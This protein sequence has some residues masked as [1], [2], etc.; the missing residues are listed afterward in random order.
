MA[1][2][3]RC[4]IHSCQMNTFTFLSPCVRA[5]LGTPF[6]YDY[7]MNL[8]ICILQGVSSYLSKISLLTD[9][10]CMYAHL[11][12]SS[13]LV[14]TSLLPCPHH[15]G[16]LPVSAVSGDGLQAAL[17]WLAVRL[18]SN[19]VRAKTFASLEAKSP[20]PCRNTQSSLSSSASSNT[21]Q[22]ESTK[23]RAT[24]LSSFRAGGFRADSVSGPSSVVSKA[25]RV[26][27]KIYGTVHFLRAQSTLQLD[28]TNRKQ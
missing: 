23:R 20:G 14:L 28:S 3:P 25:V 4:V 12:A 7:L 24:R 19:Q 13:I 10:P 27:T 5:H 21:W 18:G 1:G 2:M 9:V 6:V 15:S 8:N 22:S 26:S 16:I 11:D 17:E